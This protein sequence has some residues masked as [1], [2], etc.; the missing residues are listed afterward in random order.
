MTEEMLLSALEE[1]AENERRAVLDEARLKAQTILKDAQ[2][3]KEKALSLHIEKFKLL[4]KKKTGRLINEAKAGFKKEVLQMKQD[5]LNSVFDEA[6]KRL[7]EMPDKDKRSLFLRFLKEILSLADKERLNIGSY[8]VYVDALIFPVKEVSK[9]KF[10]PKK[11]L[12][13]VMLSTDGGR[14]KFSNTL[15]S[16]FE[17]VKKESLPLIGSILFV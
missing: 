4:E 3:R 7:I 13:G 1:E 14:I 11:G 6:W 8:T 5:A 16:R 15:D 9:V 17:R 12:N 2:N 10:E